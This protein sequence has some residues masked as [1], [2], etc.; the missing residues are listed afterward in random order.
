MSTAADARTTRYLETDLKENGEP[1]KLEVVLF[2]PEGAGPFPLLVFNHGSTGS[3]RKQSRIEE[4]FWTKAV[5]EFFNERGWIVAFPQRRGRGG[6][7]GLY[8]EG[9]S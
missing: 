6:S 8:D 5:T 2:T 4:T 9:F 1:I 3:G 7:G